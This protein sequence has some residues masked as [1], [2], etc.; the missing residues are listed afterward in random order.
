MSRSVFLIFVCLPG[1]LALGRLSV[2]IWNRT[3]E[4]WLCEYGVDTL[5]ADRSIIRHIW[6]ATLFACIPFAFA[7]AHAAPSG[8]AAIASYCIAVTALLQLAASD[9]SYLILPDQWLVVLAVSGLPLDVPPHSRAAG[10]LIPLA[11]FMLYAAIFRA[12]GGQPGLG[13]GDAKLAAAVGTALGLPAVSAIFCR[14]FLAAGLW[15]AGLLAT[16]KAAKGDRIP[17]GPFAA[18]FC[19]FYL[20]ST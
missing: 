5:D 8:M 6:I 7:I 13:A 10:L 19:L 3:P 20:L 18:C 1:A 4:H 12:A 2:W 11:L 14:A 15:A 9:I 16:K 17:F